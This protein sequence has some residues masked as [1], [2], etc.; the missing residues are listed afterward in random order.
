MRIIVEVSILVLALSFAIVPSVS[1]APSL[2]PQANCVA[3]CAQNIDQGVSMCAT[4]NHS[5]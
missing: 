1:A 5:M 4:G 3:H 2:P